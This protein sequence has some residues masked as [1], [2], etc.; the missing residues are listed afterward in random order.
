MLVLFNIYRGNIIVAGELKIIISID[1]VFFFKI[2]PRYTAFNNVSSKDS[3]SVDSLQASY[4]KM[5][6]FK[7]I[8]NRVFCVNQSRFGARYFVPCLT[9]RVGYRTKELAVKNSLQNLNTLQI[10]SENLI[11]YSDFVSQWNVWTIISIQGCRNNMY[12]FK[13]NMICRMKIY[14]QHFL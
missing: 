6:T 11:N 3:Q 2:K 1:T 14:L 4:L 9:T 10:S 8:W 12:E 13:T 5:V 7:C